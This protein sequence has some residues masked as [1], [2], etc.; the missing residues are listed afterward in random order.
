ME[1]EVESGYGVV[2]PSGDA[3]AVV[4]A[5]GAVGGEGGGAGEAEDGAVVLSEGE[6]ALAGGLGHGAGVGR[7]DVLVGFVA[8]EG[9][10]GVAAVGDEGFEEGAGCAG[11][12]E[13]PSEGFGACASEGDHRLRRGVVDGLNQGA[14]V[15]VQGGLLVGR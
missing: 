11:D 4:A 7:G 9:N 5:L 3:A 10:H 13:E 14:D 2:V 12:A 8:E 1:D 15:V 6:G